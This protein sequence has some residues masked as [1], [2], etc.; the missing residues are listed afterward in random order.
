MLLSSVDV[1]RASFKMSADLLGTLGAH[2]IRCVKLDYNISGVFRVRCH[3]M[4]AFHSTKVL[5]RNVVL[6]LGIYSTF[7]ST[8]Y[9]KSA[10]WLLGIMVA[11]EQAWGGKRHLSLLC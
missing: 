8:T 10:C 6:L 4:I 9:K 1:L 3:N 2:I 7:R 5:H 11:F